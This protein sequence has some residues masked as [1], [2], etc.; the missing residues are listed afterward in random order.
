M[1][2]SL[3]S[4]VLLASTT[5]ATISASA[6]SVSIPAANFERSFLQSF[7]MHHAEAIEEAKLCVE[8]AQHPELKSFCEMTITMQTQE[9]DKMHGWLQN[10]YGGK[11]DAPVASMAK[12]QAQHEA[13]MAKLHAKNGNA[14]DHQFLVSMGEHHQMGLASLSACLAHAEHPELKELCTKMKQNQQEDLAKMNHWVAD[15]K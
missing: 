4:F 14:F 1:K 3:L 10:W 5:F 8:K 9:K 15:W 13:V 2:C 6:Q 12:M 7:P 11:G